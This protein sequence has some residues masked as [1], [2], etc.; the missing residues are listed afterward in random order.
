M[1]GSRRILLYSHDT[2]G[3]GHLRR[4]LLLAE[5]LASV[6]GTAVLLATGS[7]RTQAFDLPTGCDTVKLP[8]VLKLPGGGYRSRTLPLS[9][10]AVLKLRAAILRDTARAFEPDLVLVDHAPRGVGG[11]LHPLL[12]SLLRAP[13]RPRI[14]LGLRDVIDTAQRVEET[15]NRDGIWSLIDRVYD[16]ILVYGDA[17]LQTTAQELRLEERYP[18]RVQHVGYLGR[19]AGA[20]APATKRPRI[21]VTVGGGGD[22]Q[23]LLRA[24]AAFLEQ[25][26]GE[27]PFRSLVLAGP[28]L[29]ERR[30]REIKR[31]YGRIDQAITLRRFV[32]G[33]DRWIRGAAGVI[34]MAGY[35]TA[36]EVLAS[37]VPA[38]FVP[39]ERP[40]REQ[41]LRARRLA[42]RGAAQYCRADEASPARIGRFVWEALAAVERR[43]CDLRLDGVA[44]AAGSL[45]ELLLMEAPRAQVR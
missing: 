20:L 43:P 45:L 27:A 33:A 39:R 42:A 32:P 4:S 8:A 2:Y 23:Q 24:Y 12:D 44:R 26:E 5:E 36:V 10:E 34:A 21:V 11:E 1:T 25:L 41:L 7:P 22:G 30:Y 18:G 19:P 40:R 17:R 37:G 16:R 9:I 14:A 13:R 29:S 31:R 6:P 38:L 35:N 28:F 3:L 15:W